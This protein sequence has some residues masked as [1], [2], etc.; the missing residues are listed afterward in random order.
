MIHAY[1]ELY[2]NGVMYNL[3]ALFDIGINALKKDADEFAS[4]FVKSNIAY[5][6]E[7]GNPN[8]LL[9]KSA[10]ELLME[11]LNQEIEYNLVPINRSPEYW[12][13]WVLAYSMW[14][15]NKSFKEIIDVIPFSKL[16]SLYNPYHEASEMKTA[17]RIKS[18]FPNE[19]PLKRIRLKRQLSQKQL[20]LLSGVK[21]RNIE[22]YEQGDISIENAKAETL[23]ALSKALDCTIEDFLR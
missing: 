15:L 7:C 5:A 8:Y 22:C 4:M 1:N 18:L 6:I 9:G 12:A 21:L 2:L 20:S 3:S 13:G 10:T 19:S 14:Y 11:L 16:I 17:L 23:Y